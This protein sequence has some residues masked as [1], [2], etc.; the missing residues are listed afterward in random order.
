MRTNGQSHSLSGAP[1]F[2]VAAAET[3]TRAELIALA[4]PPC[5]ECGNPVQRV[6]TR[7]LL[8]KERGWRPG[9]SFMVCDNAHRVL[10]KPL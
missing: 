4:S 6:E 9:P 8:D 1:T 3:M 10:V 2:R 5:H 7:W